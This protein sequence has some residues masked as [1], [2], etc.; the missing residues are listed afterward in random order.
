MAFS[1]LNPAGVTE[2][3]FNSLLRFNKSVVATS[4][5]A[6]GQDTTLAHHPNYSVADLSGSA[7][8]RVVGRSGAPRIEPGARFMQPALPQE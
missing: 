7:F 5:I 4:M 1:L 6:L 8:V 2:I 3:P